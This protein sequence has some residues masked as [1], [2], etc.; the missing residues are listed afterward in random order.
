MG[1]ANEIHFYLFKRLDDGSLQYNNVQIAADLDSVRFSYSTLDL[2]ASS[3]V[4]EIHLELNPL[5]L[6][7]RFTAKD[8]SQNLFFV[9]V[10]AEGTPSSDT[11]CGMDSIITTG[12]T[13]DKGSI[14][15]KAMCFVKTLADTCVVPCEFIDYILGKEALDMAIKTRHYLTAVAWYRQLKNEVCGNSVPVSKGCNCKGL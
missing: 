5:Q 9:Y 2:R 8:F 10:V 14:A 13:Y 12:V 11:P 6:N 7:E 3:N 4:K 1:I 15:S